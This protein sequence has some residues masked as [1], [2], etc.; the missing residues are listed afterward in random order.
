MVALVRISDGV[1]LATAGNAEAFGPRLR[2][3]L[4]GEL[5][6]RPYRSEKVERTR[7]EGWAFTGVPKKRARHPSQKLTTG[8]VKAIRERAQAGISRVAIAGEFNVSPSLVSKIVK[9][10]VAAWK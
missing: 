6:V 1:V 4:G 2:L 10:R 5:E 3:A 9:G 8:Q 7:G